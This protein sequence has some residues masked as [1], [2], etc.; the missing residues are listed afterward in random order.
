MSS[1]TSAAGVVVRRLL[2]VSE[3][4]AR[5][6]ADVL[7]DCVEGGASVSFMHPLPLAKALAFW[8]GVADGVVRGQRAL[9]VAEDGDGIVGT[10]QLLLAQPENQP[11]RADLAK[12][13]VHRRARRAGVGAALLRAI[14]LTARACGRSLLVLD[15]ASDEA[16]RLYARG[17]WT[18]LGAIPGYALLPGGGLCDTH[19]FYRQL[20][21]GDSVSDPG[22]S[23][24]S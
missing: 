18:R 23:A 8:H 15:T 12:M 20:D 1:T 6:L 3:M 7:I 13:L 4:E 9:L 2:T 24:T 10:A 14:E 19:Y 17:G 21:Q 11:H 5:G 16:A 22:S